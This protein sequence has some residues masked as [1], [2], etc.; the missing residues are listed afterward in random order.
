MNKCV[1]ACVMINRRLMYV[2]HYMYILLLYITLHTYVHSVCYDL[3]MLPYHCTRR[4]ALIHVR[5][6][7]GEGHA[8]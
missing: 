1:S 2:H 6:S 5:S 7:G 8:Q 3:S 4:P